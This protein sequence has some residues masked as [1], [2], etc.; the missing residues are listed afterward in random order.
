VRVL[1][2]A[3]YR[4]RVVGDDACCGL[5]WITTGQLD[6]ARARMSHT[7]EVLARHLDGGDRLVALE[8]SCLSAVRGDGPALAATPDAARVA[9]ELRSLAELLTTTPG[10]APPSLDG[11]EVVAQPH[12]HQYAVVGWEADAALLRHAGVRL[13]TVSGCCGLAGNWGAERGHHDVS[14]AIA[15][16]QLAPALDRAPG[17]VVLAAGFSCRPPLAQLGRGRGRHLAELLDPAAASAAREVRPARLAGS[18]RQL[19]GSATDRE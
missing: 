19:A 14:M 18:R 1:E 17:A 16:L 7:V 2:A 6:Q 12:C 13:T 15:G 9:G 8:P 11:V 10:W 4:V 5:T 3:G